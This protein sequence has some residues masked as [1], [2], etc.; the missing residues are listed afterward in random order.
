MPEIADYVRALFWRDMTSTLKLPDGFDRRETY[1][2]A[3]KL[4][5]EKTL[6][7]VDASDAVDTQELAEILFEELVSNEAFETK[8]DR[9]AGPYFRPDPAAIGTHRVEELRASSVHAL[10]S[11]IGGRFYV[12]VF[13]A[14]RGENPLSDVDRAGVII[15]ASDRIVTLG[16]NQVAELEEPIEELVEALERDNG[17]PDQPGVRERLLGQV[18]AGRELIRA[19]TFKAYV[20]YVT[21]FRALGELIERYKGTAVAMAA[22]SLVD[23]LIKKIFEG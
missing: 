3:I 5:L 23:L 15:P 8:T 21:L 6:N 22:A 11:E 19:G 13:E 4:A 10:A 9:F 2:N 14:F 17:V 20:L 7:T 12:D 18:K 1:V 16:H